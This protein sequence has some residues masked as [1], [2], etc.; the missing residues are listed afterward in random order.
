MTEARLRVTFWNADEHGK[1]PDDCRIAWFVR[2]RIADEFTDWTTRDRAQTLGEKLIRDGVWVT[3][4]GEVACTGCRESM[5]RRGP[6]HNIPHTCGGAPVIEQIKQQE[7]FLVPPARIR[8]VTLET[9]E[10]TLSFEPIGPHRFVVGAIGLDLS[11]MDACILCQGP[12]ADAIH[13]ADVRSDASGP[14]C[15]A[16]VP[17]VDG[18]GVPCLTCGHVEAQHAAQGNGTIDTAAG[19]HER[20]GG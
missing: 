10:R 2:G 8:E 16:F 13:L 3:V 1:V 15:T 19:W 6:I 11:A 17:L 14:P 12:R 18:V 4:G 5:A 20:E 7:T 9:R